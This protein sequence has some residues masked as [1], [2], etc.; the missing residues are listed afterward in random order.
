MLVGTNGYTAEGMKFI[1]QIYPL[2]KI[3]ELLCG[4]KGLRKLFCLASYLGPDG[5]YLI[6]YIILL[7][8]SGANRTNPG[9]DFMVHRKLPRCCI[10]FTPL[11]KVVYNVCSTSFKDMI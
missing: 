5:L 7:S 8:F 1:L 4:K 2:V 3:L 11:Q 9:L 10:P 6:P